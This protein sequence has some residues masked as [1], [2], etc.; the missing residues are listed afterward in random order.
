MF[1]RSSDP[2]TPNGNASSTNH[3]Y[4]D[5]S[6]SRTR[7]CARGRAHVRGSDC[8][9]SRL[10]RSTEP[11]GRASPSPPRV[12]GRRQNVHAHSPYPMP[13]SGGTIRPG[14]QPTGDPVQLQC[15]AR[16]LSLFDDQQDRC[17]GLP[18]A[19]MR[20]RECFCTCRTL[21]PPVL[22][23]A[24]GTGRCGTTDPTHNR[25]PRA[26]TASGCGR[27]DRCEWRPVANPH[28]GQDQ[29]S[30][31]TLRP[32]P[33]TASLLF[34]TG[35]RRLALAAS[36]SWFPNGRHRLTRQ[37]GLDRGGLLSDRRFLIHQGRSRPRKALRTWQC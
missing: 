33:S 17:R 2:L 16:R 36:E 26:W 13:C 4:S 22:P 9:W 24:K 21:I 32:Q 11:V 15:P 35:T 23:I 20:C 34:V 1:D 14:I 31:R 27:T 12:A 37:L 29:R 5:A 18:T 19:Q 8:P 28:E 10:G 25:F 7:R 30:T 6:C 3:P